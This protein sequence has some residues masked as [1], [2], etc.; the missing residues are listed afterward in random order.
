MTPFVDLGTIRR[1]LLVCGG[2]YGNLEAL[3]ALDRW[4]LLH[5]FAAEQ[6]IHTGDA[7]AYCADAAAAC[8]F[9]RAQG[10]YAI[11]GNVEEQL[12]N[13]GES[14][15][16]GYKAGSVCDALSDKWFGHVDAAISENE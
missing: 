11:K 16:C 8:A 9:L 14:C 4:A 5:G 6:I 13:G 7:V 3:K 1:P 12:A 15:A 2:A 10:W